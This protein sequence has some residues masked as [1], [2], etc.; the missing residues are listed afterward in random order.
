MPARAEHPRLPR[1]IEIQ[2][3]GV[4]AR[5]DAEGVESALRQQRLLFGL[6]AKTLAALRRIEIVVDGPRRSA[7]E[8][9]AAAA[10]RAIG[11]FMRRI[12]A[13][14]AHGGNQETGRGGQPDRQ[15]AAAR[16]AS[17]VA[18]GH[19]EQV[20]SPAGNG[21]S[22]RAATKHEVDQRQQGEQR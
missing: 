12:D 9:E 17:G 19:A 14:H 18:E 20:A 2:A 3:T 6:E 8:G 5:I 13:E 15:R 16:V 1:L 11:G 7:D 10:A 22:G 4:V 21:R